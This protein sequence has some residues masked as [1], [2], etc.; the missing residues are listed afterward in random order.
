MAHRREPARTADTGPVA[1][2]DQAAL[3]RRGGRYVKPMR[4]G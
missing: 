1:E 4:L 2:V 3:R